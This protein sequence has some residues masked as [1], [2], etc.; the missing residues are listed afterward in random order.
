MPS[1]RSQPTEFA[2][3]LAQEAGEIL[4]RYSHSRLSQHRKGDGKNDFAT[5]ADL[6]SEDF[7][8]KQ[9]KQSFLKDAILSEESSPY[10]STHSEYTWIIDPLDGTHNFFQ[11]KYDCGVMI[12]RAT[13][14]FVELAV[15]YNPFK[16]VLM[17][18]ERGEGVYVNGKRALQIDS[19]TAS[20][21]ADD[22]GFSPVIR[23]HDLQSTCLHSSVD[24]ALLILM[25]RKNIYLN[26]T[27]KVWDLAPLSLCFEE[28][29][30]IVKNS[31]E[32]LFD[33]QQTHGLVAYPHKYR[34]IVQDIILYH[35]AGRISE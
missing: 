32:N 25:G 30:L 13:K 29:G 33:W 24:N 34:D 15:I 7:L 31:Y 5:E 10:L 9:I 11:G 1:Y 26:A 12:A 21:V 3:Q 17:V 16:D 22:H 27:A 20:F 2:I 8:L 19:E 4:Q 14:R 35:S 28:L 6:A 23:E 18:A